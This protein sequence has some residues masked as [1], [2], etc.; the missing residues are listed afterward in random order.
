MKFF[1]IIKD[2]SVRVPDKN[3]IELGNKPMYMHLLDELKPFS[4]DVYI[5]T[6][7]ERIKNLSN[8]NIIKR[9]MC[10]ILWEN[11]GKNSPVLSMINGF[12][13]YYVEDE[14]EIIVTPH[15]TSPF[16]KL[17]TIMDA[18]DKI[19][20]YDSVVSCTKHH[21]FAYLENKHGLTPLNFN[22][23][24]VSRTQDLQPIVFQNGA[25]FAFTKKTFKIHNNRI[26]SNPYYY[27]LSFP[28]NIEIDTPDDMKLAKA[29]QGVI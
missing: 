9:T 2:K 26:G 19:G 27:E 11:T 13:D 4:G 7:S 28:E 18:T 24:H 20:E 6:D 12:L 25:F 14:N 10:H 8:F 23:S 29:V 17:S 16:I 3:F 5:N 15:V 1:V 21:E 22:T